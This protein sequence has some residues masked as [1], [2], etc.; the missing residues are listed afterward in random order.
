MLWLSLALAHPP[1]VRV[2]DPHHPDAIARSATGSVLL[3]PPDAGPWQDEEPAVVDAWVAEEAVSVLNLED[4][5]ARG[6]R[7]EGVKIAVFDLQWFGAADPDEL[8]AFTTHDCWTDPSC[9]TPI[10]V[11]EPRFPWEEGSHGYACAEVVHD[12]APD[13][14]L[15]LVRVN[16]P[17]TFENAIAWA[18]AEDIDI[19]SISMSFF[20]NSYYDGSGNVAR[21]IEEAHANGVLVV[22]SAGNYAARHWEGAWRDE[23]GDNRHDFDGDN[24][25][26]I[27]LAPGS[28]R[29]IF[30]AWNQYI[31]CGKTDLDA[32][33]I[34]PDGTIAARAERSQTQAAEQ[35]SP[36]E[37][38]RF[39]P[40]VE[41]VH[42]L[43]VRHTRGASSDLRVSVL[44]LSGDLADPV[45][46]GAI[47]DPGAS[48]YAL[49]VGAV[50]ATDD[51]LWAEP[52]PFSS[53]G[54]TY[55]GY[56]KPDL[57]G[58]DGLSTSTYGARGF[59]G[60]SA[61]TPAVAATIAVVLSEDPSL[62]ALAAA[63]RV[64]AW[65][66]NPDADFRDPRWGFG[67]VRLPTEPQDMP[68]GR[69]PL[70]AWMLLP[71]V[72]MLRRRDPAKHP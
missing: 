16:G 18:I 27:D 20:N 60:T 66:W 42:R 36:I 23:D 3:E 25:L 40:V 6:A 15:H 55:G 43:E 35:C 53:T 44:S 8:G 26:A 13:A 62:D 48:P 39:E 58:P 51:Y 69:R 61:S 30:V 71:L 21:L 24:S 5:H 50:R 12:I 7:G 70:V 10:E 59:Y 33:V 38:I 22:A 49:T 68:C 52:E 67:K 45:T 46:G 65:A 37:R 11:F 32:V 56:A 19:V 28:P 14:E 63:E 2:E 72:W 31:S 54:P 29:S 47:P 64:K 1:L 41:G 57:A 4:W 17:T 34:A 9:N